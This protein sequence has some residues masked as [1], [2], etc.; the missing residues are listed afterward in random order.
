MNEQESDKSKICLW[1]C[2]RVGKIRIDSNNL[3]GIKFSELYTAYF[4][5]VTD[6]HD[7]RPELLCNK[8][9]KSDIVNGS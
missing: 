8:F 7:N 2:C 4:A 9:V 3:I 6:P 5:E 1:C